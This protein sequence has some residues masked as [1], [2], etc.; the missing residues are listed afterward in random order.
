MSV[1]NNTSVMPYR[2]EALGRRSI[3][4]E[5]GYWFVLLFGITFLL[6][7]AFFIDKTK[8]ETLIDE[9]MYLAIV[10]LAAITIFSGFKDVIALGREMKL[11][12]EQAAKLEKVQTFEGFFQQSEDS[13]FV[14]HIKNLY[15]IAVRHPEVSQDNL[16]EI[17]HARLLARNRV[18]ELFSSILITLGLIGTIVGLIV[19]MDKLGETMANSTGS[20]GG[21]EELIQ[22]L[23]DPETGGALSG[24]GIAFLTTLLGAIFGGVVL[25]VLTS[26]VDAAIL[27]YT[28]HL[29]ELTEVYVLPRMRVIAEETMKRSGR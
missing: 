19:M 25:R 8:N 26:V 13:V 18:N 21:T 22:K 15:R 12:S 9:A 16:I 27:R 10:G 6:A 3:V 4:Q 28:A 5:W 17:I 20:S 1:K 14:E 23:F 7:L 24:L 29:A 2:S 11:A